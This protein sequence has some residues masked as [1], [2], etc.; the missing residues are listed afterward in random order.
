NHARGVQSYCHQQRLLFKDFPAHAQRLTDSL[1]QQTYEQAGAVPLRHLDSPDADKEALALDL[2]RRH[3]RQQG[4]LALL[5]CQE[6]ALTYR[7][8]R[9]AQ[10]LIE[11][12]KEKT[13]CT[14][15]YHYFQHQD[16]GLCWVRI[17]SW[18]PFSARVGL[19]GRRWLAQQLD[20]RGVRYQ[21]RDNL[22]SAVADVDLAQRLLQEQVH[23][24]WPQV[25][26]ELVRPVHPLWDYLHH[27]ARAPF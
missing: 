1:R 10:G 2:A 7:V 17:Q 3:G 25:L 16:L 12:R 8:R 6:S 21:R 20:R 11:P 26:E 22:I 5:T 27:S 14:H 9:N 18:F 4:R 13:R 19:N 23:V 15:Y 24:A